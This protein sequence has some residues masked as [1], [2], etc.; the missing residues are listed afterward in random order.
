MR[1][2]AC[3]ADRTGSELVL[4]IPPSPPP[5][6]RA[7]DD[8]RRSAISAL[9]RPHSARSS[10]HDC[11]SRGRAMGTSSVG[12]TSRHGP[13]Y[14][15]TAAYDRLR[16]AAP[17]ASDSRTSS[18]NRGGRSGSSDGR[19]CSSSQSVP[20]VPTRWSPRLRLR[21][22][23]RSTSSPRPSLLALASCAA[24]SL[25][26][27]LLSARRSPS[28]Y[29]SPLRPSRLVPD[30][31]LAPPSSDTRDETSST[32]GPDAASS[33]ESYPSSSSSESSWEVIVSVSEGNE[34]RRGPSDARRRCFGTPGPRGRGGAPRR[35]RSSESAAGG[36]PS[37][38]P[39]QRRRDRAADE[40][41]VVWL[42]W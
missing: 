8:R 32:S 1:R 5:P 11:R 18:V 16:R 21:R 4:L 27:R 29:S 40:W 23:A 13:G 37:R 3:T 31:R 39:S 26:T 19:S 14:P 34:S 35:I 22:G 17:A 25:F 15:S 36:A 6:P 33:A 38:P 28:S 41:R 24:C 12:T 7:L 42:A 30:A 20:T 10:V 2:A 9:R